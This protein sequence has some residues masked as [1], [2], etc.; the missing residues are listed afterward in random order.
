MSDQPQ[1]DIP[2]ATP[3]DRQAFAQ[4]QRRRGKSIREIAALLG[5]SKSTADR[6]CK[7]VGPVAPSGEAG[8]ADAPGKPRAVRR[9][10]KDEGSWGGALAAV[11]LVAAGIIGSIATARYRPSSSFLTTDPIRCPHCGN[12]ARM[13]TIPGTQRVRCTVCGGE[14]EVGP[15]S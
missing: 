15:P 14:A 6:L 12:T 13:V 4:A 9:R 3:E 1:D 5:V 2:Q 7:D 8:T 11:G 10:K